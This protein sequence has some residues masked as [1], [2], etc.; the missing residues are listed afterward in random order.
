MGSVCLL[1]EVLL[2]LYSSS[3]SNDKVL[4]FMTESETWMYPRAGRLGSFLEPGGSKRG[5]VLVG[6]REYFVH[7]AEP[8]TCTYYKWEEPIEE[9]KRFAGFTMLVIALHATQIGQI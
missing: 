3:S 5:M 9:E 6:K 4:F 7:W 1:C 2:S 8:Y